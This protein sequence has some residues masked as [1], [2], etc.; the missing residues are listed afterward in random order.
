MKT[1]QTPE[2]LWQNVDLEDVLTGSPLGLF[3]DDS[4]DEYVNLLGWAEF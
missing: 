1:Y 4:G 2:I 3:V